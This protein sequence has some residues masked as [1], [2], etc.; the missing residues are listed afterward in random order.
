MNPV[1]SYIDY[2]LFLRDYYEEQKKTSKFFSY[3]YFA[4]KAG[5]NSPNFLKQVVE[6]RRNLTALTIDKFITALKFNDKEGLFFRHLVLFNQAKSGQEKQEHYAVMVS[7]MH[8]VKEQRLTA[9]QHEYYNHWFV[10]VV[11]ELVTL[12]DYKEDYK[13]LAAAVSPPI[14]VREARFAVKLLKK[15]G[16]IE[17]LPGGA[18][19]QTEAAIIS[20]SSVARMAVRS[21][22]REML[23]KAEIAL[24]NTPV[25][26]RQIYG[27]TVGVSKECYDVLAAEMAAFR[28]RVVAITNRD[29]CSNRVYQMHLQLFPLSRAIDSGEKTGAQP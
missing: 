5:I 12:Y 25:E 6:S 17:Q 4:Q 28:D 2:R 24:D 29:T 20:D 26:E 10:P 22:N 8:T 23:K 3:R 21:F 1:F 13:K 27:V 19:R 14:S 7:M 18:Y 11:R 15:L 16:M 9:L